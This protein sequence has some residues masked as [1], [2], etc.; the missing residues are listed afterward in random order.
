[1]S[2]LAL[3]A[4]LCYN[5]SIELLWLSDVAS[6]LSR[7]HNL[8]GGYAMDTLSPHA[9]NG[10]SPEKKCNGT[11]GRMLPATPEF[12]HR[13]RDGLHTLCKVCRCAQKKEYLTR[14]E[15]QKRVKSYRKFYGNVYDAAYN[16]AYNQR[17][18]IKQR[19]LN[20]DR[21]YN[22]RPENRIRRQSYRNKHEARK[23]ALL[24]SITSEQIQ[25][26]LKAQKCTCYY[27]FTKFEKRNGRYIFH[28]EHTI[29]ISR[30]ECNPH[31]DINY[32]VLS[33]PTCNRKKRDKL[34]HE[35]PEGGRLF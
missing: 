18:E 29:P 24:G 15:V 2:E 11:C 9:D 10:K 14:P 5:S 8:D 33:C 7:E 25:Q 6:I 19:R 35:W 12:F 28:L 30:T 31:H 4:N 1:M 17:P 3:Q 26:K 22:L 27:C 13:N 23:K 20:Y 32:V 34:P 16:Q 21:A